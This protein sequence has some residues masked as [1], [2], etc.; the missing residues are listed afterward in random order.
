MIVLRIVT[1]CTTVENFVAAFRRLCTETTC[2]IPTADQRPVGIETGFS[3]RLA[4]GTPMLSGLG[5][6]I[7]SHPTADHEHRHAGILLG[8]RALTDATRPVFEALLAE[9]P[10]EVVAPDHT[11]KIA[12]TRTQLA[13]MIRP[14]A[15]MAPLFDDDAT[16]ECDD[17][18]SA[19]PAPVE[20]AAT[21]PMD[22]PPMPTVLGVAPIAPATRV[23]APFVIDTPIRIVAVSGTIDC[24]PIAIT[25]Q[26]PILPPSRPR[27]AMVAI[28]RRSRSWWREIRDTLAH[29][30]RSVRWRLRRRRGLRPARPNG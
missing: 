10:V 3:I 13:D 12:A 6:V 1:R 17:H 27:V 28:G 24:V 16:R 29:V 19:I 23:S 7:A 18:L 8:I 22:R 15:E 30:V 11:G 26:A 4:D 25:D 9:S 2:F 20:A 21:I 14:T 5:V